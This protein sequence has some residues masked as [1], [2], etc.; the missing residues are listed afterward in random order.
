[1]KDEGDGFEDH[2]HV[3]GYNNWL[4]GM[5]FTEKVLLGWR[6]KKIMILLS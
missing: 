5:S 2:S 6:V 3:S 1:M 4:N